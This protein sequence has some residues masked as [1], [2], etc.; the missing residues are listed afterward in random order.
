MSIRRLPLIAA[1]L[2]A[3]LALSSCSLIPH[4]GPQAP[5]PEVGTARGYGPPLPAGATVEPAGSVSP[6]EI[7]TEDV[8]GS[9]RPGDAT[10]EERVPEIVER[11][12]LVVGVDQSQNLLSYRDAVSGELRGFEVDLAREIARDIFG[13][14]ER[15]DF[16]FV[17][18]ADRANSLKNHD[19]DV[20]IRTMT[21]TATRQ[22][23]VSFSTPYLTTDSR[24]LVMDNS[25]IEGVGQLPGRTVC[26]ADGSTALEKARLFAPESQILKT[27]NW[28]DCLVAL[29]QNQAHAILSDDT[30]LSGIAAQDPYTRIVGMS[31]AREDY[32][33][34]MPLPTEDHDPSGLIRQ[35]NSTIE[36]IR[37]DGTWWRLYDRWFSSYL[38]TSGPPPLHYR[39]EPAPTEPEES[40]EEVD[41]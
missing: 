8:E 12:R 35:V 4:S 11:G 40:D 37:E 18:S 13:D 3:A 21:V 41:Q 20:V 34:G 5:R 30:I 38:A 32:A 22:E 6:R 31:L 28:A 26:V 39:E 17:D 29:Q 36:R 25:A 7:D 10:P 1:G 19:V 15:V 14:P 23:E 2:A 16:R 27:R 9:L 24:L 33:V